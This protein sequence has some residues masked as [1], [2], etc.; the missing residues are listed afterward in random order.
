MFHT[1]CLSIYYLL[2]HTL[3][4]HLI[5][6]FKREETLKVNIGVCVSKIVAPHGGNRKNGVHGINLFYSHSTLQYYNFAIL[7]FV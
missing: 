1:P 6:G 2:F 3:S 5:P 4:I 7:L